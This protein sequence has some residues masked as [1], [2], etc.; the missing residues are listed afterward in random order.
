MEYKKYD[1]KPADVSIPRPEGFIVEEIVDNV[2][3]SR[4]LGESEGK[5]AVFLL[6]KRG[7]DHFSV[8][9]SIQSSLKIRLNY[10]GMKD[11]NAETYQLVYTDA[12]LIETK[13]PIILSNEKTELELKGFTNARLNH[14]GNLFRITLVGEDIALRVKEVRLDPYLPAFYGY[15]RFGSRRPN[16]HIIGYFLIKRDWCDAMYAILGRPFVGESKESIRFRNLID[17]GKYEEA[18][19]NCPAYLNQERVIL[20]NF[21]HTYSCYSAIKSSIIPLKFYVEAYQSYL[22]NRLI[23]YHLQERKVEDLNTVLTLPTNFYDCDDLCKQIYIDEGIEKNSFNISEIKVRVNKVERKLLMRINEINI[24]NNV[25]TFWLE[26]GMYAT[27]VLR[28][29]IGGDPRRFT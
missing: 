18:L 8:I 20:K 7:I 3:V 1:W 24:T 23:S 28:E 13:K 26:R 16:T 15:Q 10:L 4:W 21:I 19:I 11:A 14:T 17:R 12:S 9:R 5:Y 22:M 29:L 6:K 2:P 25:L 27:V